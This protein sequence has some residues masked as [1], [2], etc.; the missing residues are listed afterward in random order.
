MQII[1]YESFQHFIPTGKGWSSGFRKLGHQC[2]ELPS[3]TY[4]ILDLDQDVDLLVLFD[5]NA[6]R[7]NDILE[8]KKIHLKCKIIFLCS[9]YYEWYQKI[10]EYIDIW[11]VVRHNN[12]K[13][14]ELFEAR[15]LKFVHIPL[16]ANEDL[17]YP[18]PEKK[19]FDVSFIGQLCHGDRGENH[20]LFP[21]IDKKYKGF[22]SGFSYKNIQYPFYTH[23][24]LNLVYNKTKVNLNF[25]YPHQKNKIQT[26]INTYLD[27][28]GRVFEIALS[29]NFQLCDNEYVN[30]IGFKDGVI[31]GNENNWLELIEYYLKNEDL[32]IK[33]ASKAKETALQY[34]TWTKRMESVI[35]IL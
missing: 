8:F 7:I 11:A 6:T 16:A 12:L 32:R 34:H 9:T 13:L 10:E 23:N 18:I 27:F 30:D 15:K 33:C 20:Y 17:F 4:S 24:S 1:I 25:H 19:E 26:D 29:G 14:Q 5:P 28:N 22:Y 3:I 31:I 21:V 35:N 2:Y